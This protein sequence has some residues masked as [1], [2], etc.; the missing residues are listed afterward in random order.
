MKLGH[1]IRKL[2]DPDIVA[3][4]REHLHRA[5]HPLSSR[6]FQDE[7][8]ANSA[9]VALRDKYPRGVKEV[10]R[11]ADTKFWIRRNVERAQDLSLD[12]KPARHILDL[13]CG[14]GYFIYVAQKLGHTG[15]GLDLD[16]QPI[17][18]DTLR[19]LNVRRIVHR[20]EPCQSLPAPERKFDLI[21]SYLTC[22]HRL[23]RVPDGNWRTWSP[24]QWQFFLDDIR[25]NQLQPAGTLL[26]EFHPQKNG[27]LYPAD[28]RELFLRNN[29]R[30]F[31]SRVFVTADD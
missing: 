2:V 27:Q 8:Q 25:T 17:F 29:A 16:E 24:D 6:K 19:L 28:V 26:L 30:L 14:P 13:G 18:R 7:L 9:W 31:R 1:K 23:E 22:F 4:T 15:V 20:I 11:F 10:H 5:L 3:S 12:R 21:T